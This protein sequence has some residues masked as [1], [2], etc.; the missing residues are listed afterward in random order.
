MTVLRK[1]A[2]KDTLVLTILHSIEPY[3]MDRIYICSVCNLDEETCSLLR[4]PNKKDVLDSLLHTNQF[5][6]KSLLFS[7][8]N[9][10]DI[11]VTRSGE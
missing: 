1:A 2:I 9:N 4:F 5:P 11:L 3:K 10:K 8:F 6:N 7:C